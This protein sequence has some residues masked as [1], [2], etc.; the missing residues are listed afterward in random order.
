MN[1]EL[2]KLCAGLPLHP[3]P[4]NNRRIDNIAHAAKRTHNLNDS[5]KQVRNKNL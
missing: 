4:D 5:E 3:L 2:K 1:S